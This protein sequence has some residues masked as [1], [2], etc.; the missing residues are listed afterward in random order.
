LKNGQVIFG[1]ALFK[2]KNAKVYLSSG[3]CT[4]LRETIII[5]VFLGL[6]AAFIQ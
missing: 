6:Q 1:I 5:G 3:N 4:K 2:H